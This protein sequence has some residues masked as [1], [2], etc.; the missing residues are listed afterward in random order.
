MKILFVCTGNTCR[1]PMAAAIA[2]QKLSQLG[3]DDIQVDSAG[4]AVFGPDPAAS[5]AIEAMSEIGIDLTD[6]RSR[7]LQFDELPTTDWFVAMTPS[8]AA[9]LSSA[10][11]SPDHIYVLN[12]PDPFGGSLEVYRQARDQ[13][14]T[15][16]DRFLK[17][18]L[19]C[20]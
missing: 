2:R 13:I 3:R 9:A 15:A 18:V 20:E 8:H 4:L 16:V 1:S 14:S 12:I 11:V 17:E 7:P 10:G 6:H 19:P 5:N